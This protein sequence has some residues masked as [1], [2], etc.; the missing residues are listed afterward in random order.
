[1][2]KQDVAKNFIESIE[3]ERDCL[4][5]TQAEMAKRLDMTLSAYK[6]MISGNSA[7]V[8]FHVVYNV[9][10]IT[11]K[12]FFELCGEMNPEVE[13]LVRYRDLP[14]HRKH[15]VMDLIEMEHQMSLSEENNLPSNDMIP[16]YT[17]LGNMEDGMYFMATDIAYMNASP[18]RNR[19]GE[20]LTCA[21]RITSNHLHPA[22]HMGDVL[23][24]SQQSPRDGDISIFINK[25]DGRCYI[26]KFHSSPSCILEPITD[27]G[28]PITIDYN[29][30]EESNQWINFGNVIAKAR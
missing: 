18:Y 15:A 16:L 30:T 27:F 8:P 9:C 17:T 3:R 14:K 26:R 29:N 19:Y 23:L 20:K 4:C 1:M 11:G 22:Y 5:I 24:I 12:S 21:V 28:I 2:M 10:H 7:N 25:G 6:Y 13:M